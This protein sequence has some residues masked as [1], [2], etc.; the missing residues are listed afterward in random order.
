MW[1]RWSEINFENHMGLKLTCVSRSC[2]AIS[3]RGNCQKTCRDTIIFENRMALKLT[4]VNRSSLA[5]SSIESAILAMFNVVGQV[6]ECLKTKARPEPIFGNNYISWR[7]HICSNLIL[8]SSAQY[9][10]I[11]CL[12]NNRYDYYYDVHHD[13]RINPSEPCWSA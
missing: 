9:W 2:L 12:S 4:C 6:S 7:R 5:I 13:H 1:C 3:R 8:N 11:Q 10:P